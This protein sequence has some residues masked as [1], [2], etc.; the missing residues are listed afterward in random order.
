MR[1]RQRVHNVALNGFN[2]G[3]KIAKGFLMRPKKKAGAS[4]ENPQ[5]GRASDPAPKAKTVKAPAP[6][7][8]EKR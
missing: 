2:V 3:R 5:G 6:S 8:A 1:M 7:K 4:I